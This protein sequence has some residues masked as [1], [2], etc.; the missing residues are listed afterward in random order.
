VAIARLG[1]GGAIPGEEWPT[2]ALVVR[3]MNMPHDM[4]RE[5]VR[6]AREPKFL[7]DFG[8]DLDTAAK[9]KEL[10]NGD[11][12]LKSAMSK[13]PGLVQQ[14]TGDSH[15]EALEQLVELV[16]TIKEISAES[17][18]LKDFRVQFDALRLHESD[19]YP[20][21]VARRDLLQM[22]KAFGVQLP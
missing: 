20:A 4:E 17:A 16:E 22:L 2:V 10:L 3:S 6:Y 1:K 7:K 21:F 5:V 14:L 8:I 11:A 9:V 13:L 18:T 19:S 15:S 12:E